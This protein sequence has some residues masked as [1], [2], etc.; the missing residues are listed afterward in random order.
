MS[1]L[2]DAREG[3]LVT[4]QSRQWAQYKR[5]NQ[6]I[7]VRLPGDKDAIMRYE[8]KG[9]KFIK[10]VSENDPHAQLDFE[11][12]VKTLN[13]PSQP[14]EIRS[15]QP[16][17]PPSKP[18]EEAPKTHY[19]CPTCNKVFKNKAGLAGHLLTHKGGKK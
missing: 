10:Y 11:E 4:L 12:G 2:K 5:P 7:L 17:E 13:V 8:R 9:F 18:S 14:S 15:E 16:S 6:P 19:T 1:S 3:T